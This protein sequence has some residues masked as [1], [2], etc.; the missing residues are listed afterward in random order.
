MQC[1]NMMKVERN[2]QQ[3][4]YILLFNK[5]YETFQT[6]YILLFS[7]NLKHVSFLKNMY[8]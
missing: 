3:Q 5:K 6:F 7:K 1:A 4:I 8:M 2:Q